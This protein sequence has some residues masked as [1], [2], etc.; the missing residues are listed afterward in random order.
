L[1]PY[2]RWHKK[3]EFFKERKM[4]V[5]VIGA[6]AIGG[7]LAAHLLKAKTN[8]TLV[9]ID[10]KTCDSIG[11]SGISVSGPVTD[12]IWGDFCM[13]QVN[14]SSDLSEIQDSDIIFVCVKTTALNRLVSSLKKVWKPGKI[15]VSMQNG[16]GTEDTL[17]EVA[18]PDHT[19]RV[20][21]NFAGNVVSP[22]TFKI[23][24]FNPP[25]Y[26]GPICEEGH[27]AA[28]K[29][30]GLLIDSHLTTKVVR[31]IQRRAYEK[32]VLNAALSPVCAITGLSMG[33]AMEENDIRYLVTGILS[34]AK[35]VGEKMGWH[36]DSS[37]E[38]WIN[39]L[40]KGGKHKPSMAEDIEAGRK[41]E[42]NYI[43]GKICEYGKKIGV[44]TPFNDAMNSIISGKERFLFLKQP[45]TA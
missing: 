12:R 26:I 29:V 20:V 27:T 44:P 37:M 35:N 19:L 41:T 43:T 3:I 7:I 16:I 40:A 42:I 30:A 8:V 11:E 28:Q 34:E 15:L 1:L 22:G 5:G 10:T 25:C 2:L 13:D 9:D 21:V 45:K 31:D 38:D 18:S 14:I 32:T 24:W 23:N 39:Y 6:G 4:K 33:E 17:A 36:F